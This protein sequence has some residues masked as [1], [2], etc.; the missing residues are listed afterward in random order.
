LKNINNKARQTGAPLVVILKLSD[1][2]VSATLWA[3]DEVYT[4]VNLS[5]LVQ[6]IA[7]KQ[8]HA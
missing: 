7:K 4:N 8:P 6:L 2:V 3:D 1:S 5:E